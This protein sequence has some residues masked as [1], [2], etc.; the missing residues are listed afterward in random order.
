MKVYQVL[1]VTKKGEYLV[2]TTPV[3]KSAMN[4]ARE[5]VAYTDIA[6]AEY[7]QS[8]KRKLEDGYFY[9][10]VRLLHDVYAI[11]AEIWKSQVFYE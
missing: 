6:P 7:Q 10:S 9:V 5:T 4:R 3:L 2:K 11:D 8:S 1:K